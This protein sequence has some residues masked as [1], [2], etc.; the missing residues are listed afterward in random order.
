MILAV[1]VPTDECIPIAEGV[2]ALA[3]LAVVLP[4]AFISVTVS[5]DQDAETVP[6]RLVPLA[7]V[8]LTTL[9]PPALSVSEAIDEVASIGLVRGPP[10]KPLPVM[11]PV[12]IAPRVAVPVR[13]D[14][15]A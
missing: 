8:G 5:S 15:V 11:L 12:V 2:S 7:S 6:A 4:L 13:I 14:F 1:L 10:V 3:M 9:L